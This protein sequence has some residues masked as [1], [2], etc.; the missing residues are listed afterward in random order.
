MSIMMDSCNV[1]RGSKSGFEKRVCDA[2]A[3]HL[4]DIEGDSA[5]HAH[6]SANQ[7]SK[8]F[9]KYLEGLFDNV[10]F[11]FKWSQDL[12]EYLRD[13]CLILGI[14]DTIPE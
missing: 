7:L 9:D 3:P 10:Y 6:N 12:Q 5:R 2:V 11:Y 14:T 13:I 1:M 8:P 4:L